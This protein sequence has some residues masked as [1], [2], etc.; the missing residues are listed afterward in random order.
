MPSYGE[1]DFRVLHS[2]MADAG[3]ATAIALEAPTGNLAG[4]LWTVQSPLVVKRLGLLVTVAFNYDTQTTE[5][6][7]TFFRRVTYGSDVGRVALGAIRLLNGTA[8]GQILYRSINDV[9]VN[10]GEQILAAITTQAVGGAGIA[11]DFL[12]VVY[13]EYTPDTPANQSAWVAGG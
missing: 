2:G 6:V 11:G 8:A 4:G 3:F 7:V 5:G 13:Y 12:P 9:K 10:V 1:Q